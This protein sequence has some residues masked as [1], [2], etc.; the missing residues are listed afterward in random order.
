ETGWSIGQGHGQAYAAVFNL[1]EPLAD[2][3]S[4]HVRLLFERY[5]SAPLGRFRISVTTDTRR[6]EAH[7]LPADIEALLT[8]P[9]GRRTDAERQRLRRYYLSVAPEL[10]TQRQ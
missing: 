7:G 3:G 4:L 8:V 9:A 2:A 10:E 1:A 6:A 5:Y